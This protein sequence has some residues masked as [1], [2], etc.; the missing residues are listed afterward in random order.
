MEFFK[1]EGVRTGLNA[2][3]HSMAAVLGDDF[4]VS[5][6][7]YFRHQFCSALYCRALGYRRPGGR[8]FALDRRVGEQDVHL[9]ALAISGFEALN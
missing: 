7:V 1:N 3:T 5:Q 4:D 8:V 9:S 2:G 6:Q